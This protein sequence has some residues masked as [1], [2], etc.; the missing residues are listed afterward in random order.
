MAT[1]KTASS[2]R[3]AKKMGDVLDALSNGIAKTAA[4]EPKFEPKLPAPEV[5]ANPARRAKPDG[6]HWRN[7]GPGRNSPSGPPKARSSTC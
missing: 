3:R 4:N 5:P 7:P 6:R 1:N 2:N